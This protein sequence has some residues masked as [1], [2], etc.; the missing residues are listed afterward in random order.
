MAQPE[1][2]SGAPKFDL[3][4]M[5]RQWQDLMIDSWGN[6]TKQFVHSDHFAAASSA[7]MDW[8]LN[9]QKQMRNNTGQFLDSLEFPKRSDIARLSKQ[10]MA[11]ETRV[12]DMEDRLDKMVNLLGAMSE[13]MQRMVAQTVAQQQAQSKSQPAA[14]PQGGSK[15]PAAASKKSSSSKPRTKKAKPA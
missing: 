14:A 1:E 3:E 13:A 9:W 4:G 2:G 8:A 6:M 10:L 15:S 12:A 11:V 5:T 7:Y